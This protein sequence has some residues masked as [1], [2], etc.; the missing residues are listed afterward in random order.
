MRF[1][2]IVVALGTSDGA[3]M[4]TAVDLAHAFEAELLG[5]F[6]E[7]VE[8]FNLAAFP[9]AGEVGFPS[10]VRRNLDV[11]AME[12]GLRAQ[13]QRLRRE[14]SARVAGLPVKWT[15]EVVRGRAFA[16]LR[17]AAEARD[18]VIVSVPRT[19]SGSGG[20]R[21]QA[22][23]AFHGLSAPVL[24]T[25][26]SSRDSTS[27]RVVASPRA[28]AAEI[29]DVVAA[30][31]PSYGRSALFVLVDAHPPHWEA[32]QRELRSLLAAHG[33][34][35]RF[36][37]LANADPATLARVIVEERSTL[38]VALAREAASRDALLDAL[39]CPLLVLPEHAS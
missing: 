21:A 17:A 6:V 15:F 28:A 12:R 39:P 16:E 8:L 19:A 32:W 22:V 18:L 9:F 33:I 14:L 7:D 5:L 20:A 35:V 1:R 26:E 29:A 3:A 36:R 4:T 24:L 10:A 37:A 25:S 23:Q 2:R 34:S 38:V 30:L 11:S 13:A 27:I 31:A